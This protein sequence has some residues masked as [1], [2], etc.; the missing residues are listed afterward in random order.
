MSS[1][2]MNFKGRPNTE[3]EDTLRLLLYCGG[4]GGGGCLTPLGTTGV[5]LAYRVP[6]FITYNRKIVFENREFFGVDIS[7]DNGSDGFCANSIGADHSWWMGLT[8]DSTA[9]IEATAKAGYELSGDTPYDI[10]FPADMCPQPTDSAW[11]NI[12]YV[13]VFWGDANLMNNNTTG[14]VDDFCFNIKKHD[15][16][17]KQ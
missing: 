5:M 8:A 4:G 10:E 9:D 13:A 12:I 2:P 15:K 7:I 16:D 14:T 1:G 11:E 6:K 3:S 17:T